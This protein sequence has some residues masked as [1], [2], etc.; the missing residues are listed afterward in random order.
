MYKKMPYWSPKKDLENERNACVIHLMGTTQPILMPKCA[1]H[2]K[3]A[4]LHL[5]YVKFPIFLT[6]YTEKEKEKKSFQMLN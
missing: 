1:T 6:T 3:L 5:K 4:T 2:S